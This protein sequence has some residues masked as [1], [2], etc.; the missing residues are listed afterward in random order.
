[1]DTIEVPG[2]DR[3]S[4]VGRIGRAFSAKRLAALTRAR[5]HYGLK[6]AFNLTDKLGKQS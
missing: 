1:V 2:F 6:T 5:H 3:S 4:V